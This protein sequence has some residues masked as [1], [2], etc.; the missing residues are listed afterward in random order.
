[1]ASLPLRMIHVC[2]F[3]L[4][5]FHGKSRTC[6]VVH[7]NISQNFENNRLHEIVKKRKAGLGKT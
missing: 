4:F 3:F 6:H 1:M 7:Y 2:I 5:I